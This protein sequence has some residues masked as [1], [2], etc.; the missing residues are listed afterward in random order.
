MIKRLEKLDSE[1]A[2]KLLFALKCQI[3]DRR[4]KVTSTLLAYLGNPSFLDS[5]HDCKLTYANHDEIAQEAK[6]FFVRL[7]PEPEPQPQAEAEPEPEPEPEESPLEVDLDD[8]E[9]IE[10]SPPKRTCS[11]E[12][13]GL[14]D[15]LNKP[16]PA[17]PAKRLSTPLEIIE[18]QMS[19]FE[20]TG[21]R[22]KVL[23]KVYI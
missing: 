15:F 18:T 21:E 14:N 22:S 16:K 7:F 1:F 3:A 23:E 17:T 6:K 12:S 2:R 5:I 11:E 4:M 8:P 13:E 20:S 10:A 19:A 9:P